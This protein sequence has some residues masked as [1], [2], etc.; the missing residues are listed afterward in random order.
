LYRK[1]K[2]QISSPEATLFK[3]MDIAD[4]EG[5]FIFGDREES[6]SYL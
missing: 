6:L 5:T 1:G 4:A 3:G 2:A